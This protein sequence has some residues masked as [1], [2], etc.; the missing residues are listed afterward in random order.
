M[1]EDDELQIAVFVVAHEFAH[2][3]LDHELLFIRP[4]DDQRQE[5]E[6]NA[7]VKE[8]G[9]TEEHDAF[10]RLMEGDTTH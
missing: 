7:L 6:A 9:L 5:E 3:Y 8:W 4:E 1:L 2:I 10:F